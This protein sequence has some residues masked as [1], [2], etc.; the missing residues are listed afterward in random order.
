MR[1][2]AERH[3]ERLGG[4]LSRY[5]LIVITGTLPG[6]CYAPGMTSFPH[7]NGRPGPTRFAAAATLLCPPTLRRGVVRAAP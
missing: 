1:M 2:L 5:D 6:I 3:R 4:V 7:T